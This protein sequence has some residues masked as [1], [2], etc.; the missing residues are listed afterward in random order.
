MISGAR[1]AVLTGPTGVGKTA[2]AVAAAERL[3]AEIISADSRQIYRYLDIGTGKPSPRERTRAPHWMVDVA[4]PDQPFTVVD[5]R[6]GAERA[7]S[8]I[9]SRGRLALVVGGTLHYLTALVDGLEPPALNLK[10]RR[11]L[12]RADER[13]PGL[14]DRWL[15]ALD[16]VSATRIDPKNRRR[17]I[18]AVEATL[19]SG[20]PFSRAG[21]QARRA[22]VVWVG[23]RSERSDLHAQ[24]AERVRAMVAAG[25]VAEARLLL[26]MG[27]DSALP[28]LSA[29]GYAEMIAVAR[30]EQDLEGATERVIYATNAY[31]RRQETWLRKEQRLVWLDA[32]AADVVDRFVALVQRA[33]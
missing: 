22:D 26:R 24:V 19:A 12:E 1:V 4:Y 29:T 25:W 11:W 28:S 9:T 7:L 13:R 3:G 31:I 8:E 15:G 27:F 23:L 21:G 5:F 16:P 33:A 30:G 17:V 10:L 14:A 2:L 18:R 32:E 20:R 6:R